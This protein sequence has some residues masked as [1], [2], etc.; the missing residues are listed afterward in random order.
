MSLFYLPFFLLA[1]AFCALLGFPV[2]G[3]ST[4]Y[5]WFLTAGGMVYTI[6]GLICLGY[7][8]LFIKIWKCSATPFDVNNVCI[9]A[10]EKRSQ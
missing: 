5:T 3:F 4:P 1:S 7:F 10:F 6:I 9:E 2:D 8:F